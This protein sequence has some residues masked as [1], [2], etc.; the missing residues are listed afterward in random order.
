MA[1][2]TPEQQ[3]NLEALRKALGDPNAQLR[4]P[5]LAGQ[6]SGFTS[7][8]QQPNQ[9]L[10]QVATAPAVIGPPTTEIQDINRRMAANTATLAQVQAQ[11]G[12]NQNYVPTK[13]E[14]DSWN[15][16]GQQAYQERTKQFYTKPTTED[17]PT[18][19]TGLDTEE[20]PE[21]K[22]LR[23]EIE[24]TTKYYDDSK[25]ARDSALQSYRSS[26]TQAQNALIGSINSQYDRMIDQMKKANESAQASLTQAGVV[27]G[28]QRYASQ[29][30]DLAIL[31]ELQEGYQRVGDLERDRMNA[32]ASAESAYAKEDYD[33]VL[34]N[35]DAADK[36]QEDKLSAIGDLQQ[37]V[38][39]AEKASMERLKF[40]LETQ[41]TQAELYETKAESFANLAFAELGGEDIE[42]DYLK[43]QELAD[44]FGYDP[45]DVNFIRT[46]LGKVRELSRTADKTKK[47]EKWSEPYLLGGDYV[48]REA[49]TG[50]I[51]TAVNVAGGGGGLTPTQKNNAILAANRQLSYRP[52]VKDYREMGRYVTNIN[53][54]MK[55]AKTTNNF[56]AVDQTLINAFNKL[57]DPTSVV[58]ES[59]YA[60]TA[61]DIKLLNRIRG[62][63]EKLLEGGAGLTS[64][65]REAIARMSKNFYAAAK[66]RYDQA[67]MEA[68]ALADELQVGEEF[69]RILKSGVI[70]EVTSET[71]IYN[72]KTY[73]K[74][75]GGWQLQE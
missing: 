27:S 31:N 18:T 36:L 47:P 13:Q 48:Q 10:T 24:K 42:A 52:E 30:Q 49:T 75:E 15:T 22:A 62:K 66:V 74:V 25:A 70:P 44:E 8:P 68:Q 54:A 28:R 67:A 53:T 37:R 35:L 5:A 46:T 29:E 69:A 3:T 55:E 43:L 39:D 50:E 33:A 6:P 17:R 72:G 64:E 9:T 41:K 61:N 65:E 57:N 4:D 63:Y 1:T 14:L 32:I 12:I 59:E 51:R 60:R 56:V 7:A 34:G 38:A 26:L 71:K 40:S 16:G 23:E 45:N 2:L 11:P 58:R 73:I 21:D 19:D 20:T